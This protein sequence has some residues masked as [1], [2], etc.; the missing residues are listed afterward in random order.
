MRKS[1]AA[2]FLLLSLFFIDSAA[3]S[4]DP[5][6]IRPWYISWGYNRDY[7]SNSDI[8]V[9][10]PGL[11][12]HFTIHNVAAGDCPGWTSGIFNKSLMGPQYNIRIGYYFN[13][14]RTLG[15]E[16]NFDHTKYNTNL[17]QIARVSGEINGQ[18]VDQNSVLTRQY[19]YYALH[20]GANLLMLNLVQRKSMVDFF[21]DRFQLA[22]ISK[23][24][25][26]VVIPHPENTIFGNTVDVGPK[27]ASNAF[28]WRHG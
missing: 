11:A 17:N 26:G 2:I 15:V 16:L 5:G 8:T 3:S 18:S 7:W 23:I 1:H 22:G 6:N 4:A 20:N 27:T 9:S 12:N 13:A 28:G 24:G 21:D 19:F 14:D 10:Q 25:G